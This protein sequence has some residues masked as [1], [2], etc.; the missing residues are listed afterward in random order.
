MNSLILPCIRLL[1]ITQLICVAVYLTVMLTFAKIATPDTALAS[2]IT[3]ADGNAIGSRLVAQNFTQPDYF[4][5]RPS[6][7]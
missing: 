2:I 7:L 4:W 6:P 3:T 5:P 1:I